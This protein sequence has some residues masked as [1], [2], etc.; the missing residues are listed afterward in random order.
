M[1]LA[2]LHRQLADPALSASEKEQLKTR[3]RKL[4]KQIGMD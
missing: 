4:E 3:I 1:I 2:G